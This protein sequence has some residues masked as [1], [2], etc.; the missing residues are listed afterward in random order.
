MNVNLKSI[1]I[2]SRET[3]FDR[4]GDRRSWCKYVGQTRLTYRVTRTCFAWRRDVEGKE[5][6]GGSE[7]QDTVKLPTESPI[8]GGVGGR[9]NGLCP[10]RALG[11]RRP[12]GYLSCLLVYEI[13]HCYLAP[14]RGSSRCRAVPAGSFRRVSYFKRPPSRYAITL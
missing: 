9:R 1:R 7:M 14:H 10:L 2:F 8:P 11:T 5:E 13:Q 4:V 6:R 3:T 12:A